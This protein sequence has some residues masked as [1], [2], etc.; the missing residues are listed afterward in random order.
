MKKN[1]S[2]YTFNASEKTVTF[3]DYSNI[4]IEKILQISNVKT[5]EIIYSPLNFGDSIN[6]K[7]TISGNILT[8]SYNTS[9]MNNFDPLQIWY[10]D[11]VYNN[12][13]YNNNL[14]VTTPSISGIQD[15]GSP[16]GVMLT[17][18]V[19]SDLV[20]I[21]FR[22]QTY[23]YLA[24]GTDNSKLG[25]VSYIQSGFYQNPDGSASFVNMTCPQQ[26]SGNT[27]YSNLSFNF[28]G[29]KLGIRFYRRPASNSN[30]DIISIIIDGISTHIDF[31]HPLSDNVPFLST[32]Y[33]QET[34]YIVAKDLPDFR[35]DGT[36]IA[37]TAT[38]QMGS[39]TTQKNELYVF[40]I[41]VEK[42]MGYEERDRVGGVFGSGQ[43]SASFA[44]VSMGVNDQIAAGVRKI[45]YYNTDTFSHVVQIQAAYNAGS[46][47]LIKTLYL[48]AAG[49]AG[50]SQEIDFSISTANQLQHKADVASKIN[51]AVIGSY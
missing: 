4:E 18:P 43:L 38:I 12:Y 33:D 19:E 42:R 50:D 2:N 11:G 46:F 20:K 47:V 30:P 39:S 34:C 9:S 7:G 1:I 31:T 26:T 44:A 10:D 37:H 41:A 51:Y 16:E 5:A 21:P 17:K 14:L 24:G 49:T 28:Y 22:P 40:G 23:S 36:P 13:D 32:N 3:N 45:M 8:L 15:N 25:N 27:A 48:S 29:S 35:A 6:R